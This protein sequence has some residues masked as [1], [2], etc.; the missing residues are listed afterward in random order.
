MHDLIYIASCESDGGIYSFLMCED[1]SLVKKDFCPCD[2]PMYMVRDGNRICTT[3]RQPFEHSP[4]SGVVCIE[5]DSHGKLS[6]S[7]PVI[8]THGRIA[9]HLCTEGNS[10]YIAN[11]SSGNITLLPDTVYQLSGH[12][13]NPDRQ[14]SPHPHFVCI[15]P[16]RKYVAAVDLGLDSI[17]TF[18]KELREIRRAAVPPGKG[19]RHLAFSEDGRSA[20]CVN[21]LSSDISVFDYQDGVFKYISTF[22]GLPKTYHG[23]S[24]AA[25]IKVSGNS[26]YISHRGY[27]CIS[28]F[29]CQAGH[30]VHE[31]DYPCGGKGPRDFTVKDG[32]LLCANLETD[33]VTVIKDEGIVF[34]IDLPSPICIIS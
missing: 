11:Y 18:D 29:S 30:I 27:D 34:K 4:C 26:I 3:L 20:F 19:C 10:V 16:D 12:G 8:S 23:E 5:S 14:E 28:K 17:I 24:T 9:A 31:A 25:A 32:F 21:E 2:R 15:T 1:G 33:S 13:P 22:E 6:S 7:G